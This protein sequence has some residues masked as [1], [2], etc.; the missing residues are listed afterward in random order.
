MTNTEPTRAPKKLRNRA[1]ATGAVLLTL[2]AL[3]GCRIMGM[4]LHEVDP[5][6]LYRSAQLTGEELAATIKTHKIKTIVN[7]RGAF[8]GE[9]WYDTECAVADEQG[10]ALIDIPMSAD[11]PPHRED[12][13]RLLDTFRDAERPMLMHCRAGAD[14]TG[15]ATAIYMLEYMGKSKAE[16]L[17]AISWDYWHVE[18]FKPAKR[19]F[20]DEVY[21]GQVWAREVY[22]PCAKDQDYEYFD[23][24]ELCNEKKP[25]VRVH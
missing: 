4:N 20:V 11:R 8:P 2:V 16:A 9:S 21:Q 10:A 23:R 3:S 13:V 12:L 14:R 18:F 19:Y 5:G 15:E 17:T 7:L 1:L 24:E 25:P 22:D 6:K